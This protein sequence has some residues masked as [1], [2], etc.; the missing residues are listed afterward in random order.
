MN[1]SCFLG[2]A[3]GGWLN[4]AGWSA[5]TA[6]FG[7]QSN[8]SNPLTEES[9]LLI[10]KIRRQKLCYRLIEPQQ[11]LHMIVWRHKPLELYNA[12]RNTKEVM[13][14]SVYMDRWYGLYSSR[15][16]T[17]HSPRNEWISASFRVDRA[18]VV[19]QYSLLVEHAILR[20]ALS[21]LRARTTSYQS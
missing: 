5:R 7:N 2:C 16:Y 15:T 4:I 6:I 10:A 9:W 18:L 13:V 17:A 21:V 14:I 20:I 19:R 3:A 1:A 12:Q 8:T 11:A